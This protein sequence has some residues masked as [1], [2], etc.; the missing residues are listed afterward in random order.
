[1]A[2]LA[3]IENQPVVV[4]EAPAWL[5]AELGEFSPSPAAL[6]PRLVEIA[7]IGTKTGSA[8]LS[9]EPRNDYAGAMPAMAG[10]E[11]FE[12]VIVTP[13]TKV[14]DF[15]VADV[16]FDTNVWNT[17]RRAIRVCTGVTVV[18][19]GN[20]QISNP[21]GWP[22]QFGP[23]Q[24][25]DFPTLVP[26]E[27]DVT[28]NAL[29]LFLFVADGGTDLRV[30]GTR[31]LIFAAEADW[32]ETPRERTQYL[33]NILPGYTEAEQRVALR[34]VPRTLFTFRVMTETRLKMAALEALLWGGQARL[35]GVPFWPDAQPVQADANA[36]DTVIYAN[37]SYRKFAAGGL[38]VLWRDQLDFEAVNVLSVAADNITISAPL[39]NSWLADGRTY[40]VPLL[41]GRVSDTP[42]GAISAE[43]VEGTVAFQCEVC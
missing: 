28:I 30:T 38:A 9:P 27:G 16:Q 1:M 2:D 3:G 13:R 33:T 31:L 40:L 18:D 19:S 23:F 6:A 35:C 34:S 32:S 12:K 20:V 4:L 17:H 7:R 22:L 39:N 25:Y 24:A 37:T 42:L 21:A 29:V 14:L 26:A 43:N 15:V 8:L 36:G 41:L 10:G 5:S 11:L